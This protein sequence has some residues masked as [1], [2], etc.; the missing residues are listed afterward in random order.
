MPQPK[1][2]C[3]LKTHQGQIVVI[4]QIEKSVRLKFLSLCILFSLSL[5]KHICL[6][7]L[8]DSV[9]PTSK[10]PCNLYDSLLRF[11]AL[12]AICVVCSKSVV[13][14]D[15]HP[16]CFYNKRAKMFVAP[17]RLFAIDFLLARVMTSGNKTE[18]SNEFTFVR[19]FVQIL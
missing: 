12:A 8:H 2:R 19:D 17:K 1:G 5:L 16:A 7:C 9:C 13:S 10:T 4:L 18:D 15:S 11:H 6:L 14:M 3:S